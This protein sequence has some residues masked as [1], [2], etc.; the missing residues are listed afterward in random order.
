MEPIKIEIQRRSHD[1]DIIC[2]IAIQFPVFE[3]GPVMGFVYQYG[4]YHIHQNS[5]NLIQS[6]NAGVLVI[7][8]GIEIHID[9]TCIKHL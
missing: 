5:S 1:L 2:F 6:W 9:I 7:V 3:D 4:Y 8:K